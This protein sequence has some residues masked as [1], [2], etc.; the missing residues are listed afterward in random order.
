L[1]WVTNFTGPLSTTN[2]FYRSLNRFVPLNIALVTSKDIDSDEDGTVNADDPEPVPVDGLVSLSIVLTPPPDPKA[3]L[4]WLALANSMNYLEY[5]TGMDAS[6]W[7]LLTNV[8]NGPVKRRFTVED[9]APGVGD[10]S[11]IYRLRM[12]LPPQ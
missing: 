12:T 4:S 7:K 10:P 1:R 2:V 6:A 11:R 5:N 3:R 9:A 8:V